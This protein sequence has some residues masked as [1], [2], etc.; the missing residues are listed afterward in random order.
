[1]E[2]VSLNLGGRELTLETGRMARQAGGSVLVTYGETVVLV[3]ATADKSPRDV[4]FLPL[5]VHY[6]EKAYAAGRIPGGFFKREGRLSEGETLISRFIDRPIR[7]LF[8]KGFNF[9]SQVIATVLSTDHSNEPAVAAMI[10]A[11]AALAISDIPFDGPIAGLRVGRVDGKFVTNPTEE[12]LAESEL[13]FFVAG[14]A[15]AI[16]MVEGHSEEVSEDVALDAVL[17]AHKEMQPV[18][19][20]QEKL[21]KKAGKAKRTFT[22]KEVD[23]KLAKA[24]DKFC[25]KDLEKA[26]QV[27]EKHARYGALDE[28]KA[29]VVEK[30]YNPTKDDASVR[31]DVSSIYSSLKSEVMRGAILDKG[32]RVDG[33][34]LREIRPIT[35][36]TG[37]LPRTHGSALFTRGETQ[38]LVTVTLGDRTDEQMIDSLAGLYFRR[39]MFHYNFPAF[40]VGE[41]AFL[42]GPGRREIGHGYLAE[43]GVTAL[44]PSADQFPYTMR[45]V[46]EILESNG[47]SS[48]ASVCGS[49]LAMMDAGVPISKH[50]AGIA[51]GLIQEGKKTA[52]L[53]DILGDED[54]LGDMDFKV[55]GTVDGVTAL[56]MDIKIG[57]VTKKIFEDAL[58]QAK[59]GR[60][61]IIGEMNKAITGARQALSTH[62]P[63]MVAYKIDKERIRDIIGPGG[64]I[65]KGIQEETGAKV[66]VSDDG[67]VSISSPN[68]AAVEKALETI[69]ALTKE[70]A[71]GEVFYGPVKKVMDFG[72]FIELIPGTDGLL[73]VSQM[74]DERVENVSDLFSEGDMVGVKVT[75]LDKRGK[76]KLQRATEE[77][78]AEVKGN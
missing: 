36:E 61:H 19:K 67:V 69:K 5:S 65:I 66:D 64:K 21:Q 59:E 6:V 32:Q 17:F 72:A 2:T 41:T 62:A 76:L 54:H 53:S 60:L 48:M 9:E 58:A 7:P 50:A 37:V 1:M 34:G 43:K 46:S 22:P 44:V 74:S 73:H 55:T 63:R 38:A 12:Q 15:D 75:G 3:A 28:L 24:V 33:R 20:A 8:P 31:A 35:C 25:R 26:L 11:S 70:I 14:S 42:R 56:Q 40:S 4:D 10:G 51:M 23:A 49:S 18:I 71:I 27:Q 57:G 68:S 16:L 39:F 45:V 77:E 78:I 29:K 13:N 52:I 47:S 30:F